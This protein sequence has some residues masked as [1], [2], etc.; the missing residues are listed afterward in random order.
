MTQN[1]QLEYKALAFATNAHGS[2]LQVRKY[3]KEPYI[4]HPIAV[5]SIVRSV[6]DHT[7][8]M[9]A[10]AYLH[11]VVEDTPVTIEEVFA[12][13]GVEVGEL[14]SWLT[15][16]SKP[17]DGN[18]R[19]RKALD[20]AH[21]IAAPAAAQTIKVADLIDNTKSIVR[22]DPSFATV[23]LREK[24]LLLDGLVRA[25]EKLREIALNQNEKEILKT[26][27]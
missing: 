15:D 2:V 23:F 19:V 16:V 27:A 17:T 22:F 9:L 26:D 21:S 13:F 6:R 12:E 7:P 1:T 4:V 24:Q 14:V 18:R 11:D 25:D 8:E 20:R 5:A 10:A 3:T